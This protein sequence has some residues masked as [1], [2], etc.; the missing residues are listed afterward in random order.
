MLAYS[1]ISQM[2]LMTVLLG[3]AMA[4]PRQAPVLVTVIALYALHHGLA[5]GALFLSTGLKLPARAGPRTL[6][7]LL[8]A[9]PALSLAGLPFTSGAVAKLLAK[10]ALPVAPWWGIILGA[11]AVATTL[12]ALRFLICMVQRTEPGANPS[13]VIPGWLLCTGAALLG[14]WWMPWT[15]VAGWDAAAIRDLILPAWGKILSLAWPLA[16][17]HRRRGGLERP[18]ATTH[19]A[20]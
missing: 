8:M 20:G 18:A 13:W 14:V 3:A 19:T 12:L 17:G 1:S 5:K 16:V 6:V 2:G 11:G 9:L 10:S 15:A 4:D 7:W